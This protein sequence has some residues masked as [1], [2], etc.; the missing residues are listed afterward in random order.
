LA[1]KFKENEE[2]KDY[3]MMTN[4]GISGGLMKKEDPNQITTVFIEVEIF[5]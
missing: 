5:E 1:W 2:I 3:S 4:A